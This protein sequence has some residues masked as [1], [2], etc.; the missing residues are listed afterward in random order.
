MSHGAVVVAR[1]LS[2]PF[3][4]VLAEIFLCQLQQHRREGRAFRETAERLTAICAEHGFLYGAA[5][6]TVRR[7]TAMIEHGRGEEGLEQIQQGLAAHRATGAEVN[8]PEF[9]YWLAKGYCA[10]GRLDERSSL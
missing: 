4:L 10:T 3:S 2:D 1:A 8:R 6:A 7:G 9:L 5:H